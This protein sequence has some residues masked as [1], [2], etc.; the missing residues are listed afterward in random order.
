MSKLRTIL[1]MRWPW[2]SAA[3]IAVVVY[4]S[5][6]IEVEV[7]PTD[8]RPIG[9]ADDI[10]ALQERDDVNVLFILIDTLRADRLGAWGYDRDTSPALDRLAANGIRFSQHVAQSSWTK[11]SMASMWTGLYPSRTGVTR[12][13]QVLSNQ[14]RMP[15][16]VFSDA[17]F[18]TVGLFRN[19]WV[20][21][22]FGFDQGFDVYVKPVSKPVSRDVRRENP[23][24]SEGGTD[25][26]AVDG[27]KEFLRVYGDER[28]FLYLHLMD[29]HE[30]LYDDE[31]AKFGTSYSDVYDNAILHTDLV[32]ERLFEELA[33]EGY[34]ENTVIV[35]GSD[36]G[37]AFSERG[38]EGHARYVYKETTH[39]PLL[40]SLPFKLEPGLVID[41][42]TR[43][44]D[45]WPTIFDLIG[46]PAMEGVDGQSQRDVILAAARGETLPPAPTEEAG[47]AHL[48]RTWG[49]A[50]IAPAQ[51]LSV[52]DKGH[53]YVRVP[54]F[55]GGYTEE[56][57]D[58]EKD[59]PELVDVGEEREELVAELSELADE[60]LEG[61]PPWGD[62]G[63][64]LEMDE[65][66]LQQLRA[67]GY[68]IP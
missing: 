58:L 17:G 68:K 66:Q 15:A 46:L 20:E 41:R 43:N 12:F 26:G 9:T 19:G 6:M 51:T 22:Y 56:V 1:S 50:G 49:Q 64:S 27:A 47:W 3:V 34:L 65:M 60:Y 57:F 30:Y 44:V 24:L 52:V 62:T 11:C 10:A 45:I 25:H 36:H 67:L 2:V 35:I 39:V 5:V 33:R 28:W 16:E 21:S 63:E 13:D 18:R 8:D 14:A 53:R 38:Y 42:V 23:T 7:V 55:G 37:E 48:D 29:L 32:L 4:L 31:S 40:V 54:A 61:K 59:W